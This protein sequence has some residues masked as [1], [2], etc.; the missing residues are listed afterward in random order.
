MARALALA[1]QSADEGE[2]PVGAVL[3][4][5]GQVLGEGRNRPIALCDPTAHAEIQALRAAAAAAGNYRLPGTTLYVT[6]EPCIMCLGAMV[7]AR[8]GRVVFGAHDPKTGALGG[9]ADALDL[10]LY[11]HA[12]AVTGGVMA[13]VCG[14]CLRSFFRARRNGNGTD[15]SGSQ[16]EG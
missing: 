5:D 4:K 8:V 1:E 11:N 14:E 16:S 10:P 12:M 2:V 3:V 7:H 9:A 6:L 15:R 13:E